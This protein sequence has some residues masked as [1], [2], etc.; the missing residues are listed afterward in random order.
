MCQKL[1]DK[2]PN[3]KEGTPPQITSAS[4]I[5]VHGRMA[6]G[7]LQLISSK[8][9]MTARYFQ[10]FLLQVTHI[11]NSMNRLIEF[12]CGEWYAIDSFL[13]PRDNACFS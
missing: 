1:L 13:D 6:V 3:M 11:L 7:D 8:K 4:N 2:Q 10:A 5:S 12:S 9:W